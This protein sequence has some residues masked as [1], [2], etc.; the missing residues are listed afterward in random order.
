MKYQDTKEPIYENKVNKVI[1][2][3]DEGK[4]KEEVAEN[5]GYGSFKALSNYMR[6]KNFSWVGKDNKFVPTIGKNVPRK[7]VLL[8]IDNT[9]VGKIISL[10]HDKDMDAKMIAEEVGFDSHKR[11]AQFMD[12]EGYRWDSELSN[13]TKV[14]RNRKNVEL[15]NEKKYDPKEEREEVKYD[16]DQDLER[17][18]PVL[19]L[20]KEKEE[21]LR[22]LL[23]STNSLN[24]MQRYAVPGTP[25]TKS[26]HMVNS[27]DDLAKKFCD[28]KNIRQRD[29]YESALIEYLSK[30][31]YKSQIDLLLNS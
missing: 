23:D 25:C 18:L 20:I 6:R 9:K 14:S 24:Q 16:H 11:L 31:G 19:E 3:L 28:E 22:T 17:Y 5:V 30:H 10:F 4:S 13:Y 7:N 8:A 26:I 2:E 1:A 15:Q 12:T 29:L 21:Q 27:L